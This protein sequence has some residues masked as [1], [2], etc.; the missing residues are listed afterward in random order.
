MRPE[1]VGGSCGYNG[2]PCSSSCNRKQKAAPQSHHMPNSRFPASIARHRHSSL[3]MHAAMKKDQWGD[4]ANCAN[5]GQMGTCNVRSWCRALAGSLAQP[6]HLEGGAAYGGGAQLQSGAL[7][8]R[9]CTA[10]VSRFLRCA[11]P[12]THHRG[13]VAELSASELYS[14]SSNY[15]RCVHSV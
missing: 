9:F 3:C 6:A 14:L 15:R 2:R 5:A 1:R 4:V 10:R 11:L 12:D 13:R 8:H 7:Y